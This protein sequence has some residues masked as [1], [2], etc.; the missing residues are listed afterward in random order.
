[1]LDLS[2]MTQA[3][4]DTLALIA[5]GLSD[6]EIGRRLYLEETGAKARVS[7]ILAI[8][9]LRTRGELIA[10]AYQSGLV[11]V[12]DPRGGWNLTDEVFGALVSIVDS[13]V[14]GDVEGA[15]AVAKRYAHRIPRAHQ[16]DRIRTAEFPKGHPE[17]PVDGPS[18]RP[19]GPRTSATRRPRQQS[20]ASQ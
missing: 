1:M 16:V 8:F 4:W 19:S 2:K 7:R 13:L 14:S 9:G 17:R 3:L 12:S 5:E 20:P 6:K 10:F 11:P 15:R 18:P